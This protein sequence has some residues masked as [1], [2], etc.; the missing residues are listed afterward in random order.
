M[1]N[2][3]NSKEE[4]DDS[5]HMLNMGHELLNSAHKD[6]LD[7]GHGLASEST[8]QMG[9][10]PNR[11]EAEFDDFC[12]LHSLDDST[13]QVL[14]SEGCGTIAALSALQQGDIANFN[15]PMGQCRLLERAMDH[16]PSH[17]HNKGNTSSIVTPYAPLSSLGITTSK[18]SKLVPDFGS[19]QSSD[20]AALGLW[21]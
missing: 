13:K 1:S 3:G 15:L 19:K 12:S 11:A 6:F 18:T 8:R 14:Q 10:N 9:Y 2:L 4:V 17:A 7:I 5:G 21:E 16:K 20:R